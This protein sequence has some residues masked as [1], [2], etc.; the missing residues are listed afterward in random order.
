METLSRESPQYKRCM[1]LLPLVLDQQA[2]SEDTTFFHRYAKNWPEILNCY[3]QETAFRLAIRQKLGTLVA[4][5][6]LLN[7]IRNSIK[8]TT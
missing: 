3:E 7:D 5:E 4:P 8:Q 6:D 1:E 2:T